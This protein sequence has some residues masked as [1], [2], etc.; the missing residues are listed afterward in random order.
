MNTDGR[1]ETQ[2]ITISELHYHPQAPTGNLLS[3]SEL[4]FVEIRNRSART[5]DVSNWRLHEAVDFQFAVGTTIDT[6]EAIVVVAFDPAAETEKAEA[7]REQY[8]I[9]ASVLLLGPFDGQLS[10][11]SETV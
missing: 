2:R 7:F 1:R 10:N 11:R 6:G 3:E 8:E 9:S 4:E 5:Q